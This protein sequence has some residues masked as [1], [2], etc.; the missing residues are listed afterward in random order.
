ME[1][2]DRGLHEILGYFT[3]NH[4]SF[5][6]IDRLIDTPLHKAVREGYWDS[7]ELLLKKSSPSN[8]V[9]C[10]GRTPLMVAALE[11]N[12]ESVKQIAIQK[13]RLG[14]MKRH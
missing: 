8:M 11:R 6:L 14:V 1:A 10:K 3:K 2:A 13:I 12:R 5:T 9:N 4:A 7:V